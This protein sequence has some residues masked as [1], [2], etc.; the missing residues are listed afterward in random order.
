[1]RSKEKIGDIEGGTLP[2]IRGEIVKKQEGRGQ[3]REILHSP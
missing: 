1:V 2:T 3:R